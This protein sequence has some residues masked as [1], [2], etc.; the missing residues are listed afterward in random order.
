[1]V[2]F[3]I[4]FIKDKPALALFVSA[5]LLFLSI[6][7]VFTSEL[8]YRDKNELHLVSGSVQSFEIKN[9]WRSRQ[10]MFIQI[11]S[12]GKIVQLIQKDYTKSVPALLTI[13]RGDQISALVSP[14][15]LGRDTDWIWE[16]RRGEEQL[17]SYEQTLLLTKPNSLQYVLSAIFFIT[18]IYLFAMGLYRRRKS[19]S[20]TN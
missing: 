1:M 6:T 20:W 9:I 14:D 16:L 18:A 2:Q 8:E 3:N 13:R 5:L 12:H 19:G 17:L 11:L 15:S 7:T 4:K 10:H